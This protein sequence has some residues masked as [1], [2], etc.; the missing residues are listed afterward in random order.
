MIDK[1]FSKGFQTINNHIDCFFN[2]IK[3]ITIDS[4]I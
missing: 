1:E 2:R 3:N 4:K